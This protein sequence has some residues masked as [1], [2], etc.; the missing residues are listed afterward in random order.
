MCFIWLLF[1]KI[2]FFHS[3]DMK[4][5]DWELCKNVRYCNKTQTLKLPITVNTKYLNK[6]LKFQQ[7]HDCGWKIV[8]ITL[9]L[10]RLSCRGL[11]KNIYK[12]IRENTRS[13]LMEFHIKVTVSL[14]IWPS[15]YSRWW[16]NTFYFIRIV[17]VRDSSSSHKFIEAYVYLQRTQPITGRLHAHM[18][19]RIV[20]KQLFQD[21]SLSV[22]WNPAFCW[23]TCC[24]LFLYVFWPCLKVSWSLFHVILATCLLFVVFSC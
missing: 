9:E 5:V 1:A 13:S 6:Y 12:S 4:A 23:L 20:Y 21:R 19:S 10:P 22:P 2:S 8:Y 17:S 16:T 14:S 24:W 11:Y 3:K 15:F 18:H 7:L